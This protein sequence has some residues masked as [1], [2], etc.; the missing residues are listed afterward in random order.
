MT[1]YDS[2]PYPSYCYPQSSPAQLHAIAHLFGLK[3]V[4][5]RKAKMLEIGCA[6]GGNI[7]PLAARFPESSFL[8]IDLSTKQI[9]EAT[10]RVEKLGLKNIQFVAASMTEHHFKR[11]KFDYIIS[12]G[13]YSWI[14][15]DVQDRLLEICGDTLSKNGVAYISYNTLPGWNA[16]KTVRDMMVWHSQ[17]FSEPAQKIREARNMIK[18]VSDNIKHQS[19]PY[20]ETL[21]AELKKLQT[22]T[23]SYLFHEHL[24]AVNAPCY[25]YEFADKAARHGLD[26]LGETG[27]P[28]M[29]LGNHNEA[30]SKTL[31]KIGDPVRLEQYLDFITNRRFRTT[32]LVKKGAP[33]SRQ[34]SSERLGNVFFIPQ[35]RLEEP[36]S[37]DTID[38]LKELDLVH[39]GS[40]DQKVHVTGRLMCMAIIEMLKALPDRLS[41][42]Q[43][44]ERSSQY[45][46][47]QKSATLEKEISDLLLEFVF[48]G[49]FN[50][51]SY[52]PDI[53]TEVSEKPSAFLP[54]IVMGQS[55]DMLPNLHHEVVKLSNDHRLVLQYVNGKNTVDKIC[56]IIKG[57]I[58][59][60]ELTLNV[61]NQPLDKNAKEVDHHVKEYVART[62]EMFAKNALLVA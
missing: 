46:K 14:P 42:K 56:E 2:V 43:I 26:Y 51:T 59:K 10:D 4:D 29:F 25:F 5:F 35:Y 28:S 62:L 22:A 40:K 12:H 37:E 21:E 32:L 61:K 19:G 11:E 23:D 3:P 58:D 39:I 47:G 20:K 13:V 9:S 6:A 50:I 38:T 45:L 36:V 54:A 41:V 17:N 60:G 31:S 1:T 24:E 34:L 18:F 30:V 49:I 52:Q 8:G 27:L 57:H 7:L 53:C 16:V 44:V 33:V 15:E 55:M 48:K